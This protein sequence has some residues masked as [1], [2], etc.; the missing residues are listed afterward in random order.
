MSS[1]STLPKGDSAWLLRKAIERIMEQVSVLETNIGSS[2]TGNSANTQIIFN[3]NGTLR[4]DT[5]L[6]FNKTTDALTVA[7]LVTAGSATITGDLT[8]DTNVL[9]VD[10]TLNQVGIGTA[11]PAVGSVLDVA[12]TVSISGGTSNARRLQFNASGAYA[13]WIE[14][15]GTAGANYL[16]FAAGN[17]EVMRIDVNGVCTWFDGVGGTRM[18]LNS[19]GLGIGASPSYKLHSVSSSAGAT[20]Y[21]VVVDNAA[22]GAGVNIAGIGFASGGSLK[23]S[24]TSAVYGNDFLAFNVGG[25]GTTER[26]RV[27]ASGNLGVSVTPSVWGSSLK[28]FE[29]GAKGNALF[30]TTSVVDGLFM[31][32]NAYF[33]TGYKYAANGYA[34]RYTQY[35][36][37]HQWFTASSGIAGATITDFATA[38]MTL[39]STGLGVGRSPAYKLDVS[40]ATASNQL[41]ISGS[42]QNS[43]TF[44]N[45]AAGAST[46]FLVG[47]SFSSDDANNLFFY[48]LTASALRLFIGGTGNIGIGTAG[49]SEALDVNSGNVKLGNGNVILSTS[50]KGID[51]SATTPDGTG[52]VT[53]ELL[54]DYEEGTWTPVFQGTNSAGTYV[55]SEQV[56]RY[57]KVGNLVT[58]FGH[59]LISSITTPSTGVMRIGGLPFTT[60]SATVYAAATVGWVD[61]ITISSGTLSLALNLGG[62]VIDM[63]RIIS[64]APIGFITPSDLVANTRINFTATYFV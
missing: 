24:I 47:R 22:G 43:I 54:D 50:G 17:A 28:A 18:T 8:V 12:G 64:G 29:L 56:G 10:T 3:D 5:G 25:S 30:T 57:T 42:N 51:F 4:G 20:T 13:N 45:A 19:T 38:K 9:K 44:A 58:V 11:S 37:A 23:S 1:L 63:Y 33:D 35:Q 49:P 46:G 36:A 26:L 7:G 52:T 6:V 16:R 48:D 21:P 31:V 32:N 62:V 53:S 40:S 55:Y 15:D 39:D 27:D 60:S 2:T 14:A 61:N 59:L 34:S 41:R